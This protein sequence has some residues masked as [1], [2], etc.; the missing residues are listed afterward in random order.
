M[1][2][3][4]VGRKYKIKANYLAEEKACL[5]YSNCFWNF[6]PAEIIGIQK[7]GV[8]ELLGHLFQQALA[9]I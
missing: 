5:C 2:E 6:L 7:Q 9:N 4:L 3:Y 1:V 8:V